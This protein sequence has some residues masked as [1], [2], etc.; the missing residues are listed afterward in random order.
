LL[1]ELLQ[2]DIEVS[3]ILQQFSTVS[4]L[5]LLQELLNPLH[6]KEDVKR[7]DGTNFGC[8][9]IGFYDLPISLL[10]RLLV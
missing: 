3:F 2:C 9:Y 4:K 7:I 8:P 6:T 1:A 10:Q 5:K